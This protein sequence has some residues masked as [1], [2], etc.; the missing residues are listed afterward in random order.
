MIKSKHDEEVDEHG[1]KQLLAAGIVNRREDNGA[2]WTSQ[3]L[4]EKVENLWIDGDYM[5]RISSLNI[6]NFI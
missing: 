1:L 2:F 5:S 4:F 3:R 6:T